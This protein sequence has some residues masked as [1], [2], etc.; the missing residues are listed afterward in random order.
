MIFGGT[1][2]PPHL[3]HARL[4]A[5]AAAQL[6]CDEIL[7]IPAAINPLKSDAKPTSKNHRLAMLLLAIAD[8]PI[9][10]VS[11]IEL[12]RKGRSYTIDT[13][14]ALKRKYA[15]GRQ[16]GIEASGR[17]RKTRRTESS[18][19]PDFRLLIGC[20]QA[21]DFHRWKD[22]EEILTLAV[23]AVMLRPPW[24]LRKFRKE[25]QSK[26]SPVEAEKWLEWTL[27]LPRMD[28]SATEIR[29]RLHQGKSLGCT[30]R[31]GCAGR[32]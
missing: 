1:F 4:P 13:L 8:V 30:R 14:R 5:M 18:T 25:L 11:T 29:N 15:Q 22:W 26:Y 12:E 24:N 19:Q 7:Y 21:L 2:D 28:I 16:Q 23:P 20:D 10:K 31:A 32:D 17:H 6:N 3:A 27:R 9:A